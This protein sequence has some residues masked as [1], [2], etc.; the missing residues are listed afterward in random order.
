MTLVRLQFAFSLVLIFVRDCALAT[1]SSWLAVAAAIMGSA[2]AAPPPGLLGVAAVDHV[3]AHRHGRL[4]LVVFA[5]MRGVLLAFLAA[6]AF[7]S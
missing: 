6:A 7:L 3:V 2:M 5:C 1:S 4:G